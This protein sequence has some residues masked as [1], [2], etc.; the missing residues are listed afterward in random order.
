MQ[1]IAINVFKKFVHQ[2]GHWLR[3]KNFIA[4]YSSYGYIGFVNKNTYPA[5]FHHQMVRS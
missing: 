3:L 4:M 5:C 2:V 1:R